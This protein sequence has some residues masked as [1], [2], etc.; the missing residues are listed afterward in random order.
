MGHRLEF[1]VP[2]ERAQEIIAI[3]ES[4]GIAAK[5]IGRV[6][7][8]PAKEVVLTSAHGTFTYH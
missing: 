6:E 5:V 8:A 2:Q 3:S 7:S 4:F 1:Y